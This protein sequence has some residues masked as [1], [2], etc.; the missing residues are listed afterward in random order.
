MLAALTSGV[1]SADC[2]GSAIEPDRIAVRDDPLGLLCPNGTPIQITASE[3]Y[4]ETCSIVVSR[5]TA[6]SRACSPANGTARQAARKPDL[7]RTRARNSGPE[8][9]AA[10]RSAR[11]ARPDSPPGEDS[12]LRASTATNPSGRKP[13]PRDVLACRRRP[14]ARLDPRRHHSR[15]EAVCGSVKGRRACSQGSRCSVR[16]R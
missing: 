7:K 6:R 14:G 16:R 13:L 8:A 5:R 15:V 11:I 12:H 9:N 10:G 4:R 3:S 2:A 1:V